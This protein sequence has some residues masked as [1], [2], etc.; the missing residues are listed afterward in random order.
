M[1]R[2]SRKKLKADSGE[3]D[4]EREQES[5]ELGFMFEA[6]DD[7]DDDIDDDD[8]DDVDSDDDDGDEEV[9]FTSYEQNSLGLP[10]A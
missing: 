4:D 3:V 5:A 6:G 1:I 2:T 7:D 10:E 9:N 8:G